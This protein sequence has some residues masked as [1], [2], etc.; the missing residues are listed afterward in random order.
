MTGNKSKTIDEEIEAFENKLQDNVLAAYISGTLFDNLKDKGKLELEPYFETI[1]A[2]YKGKKVFI[3]CDFTYCG[4][5]VSSKYHLED[6]GDK[7]YHL[8]YKQQN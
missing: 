1:A 4:N 7:S 6:W 3:V 2:R 8:I 5:H